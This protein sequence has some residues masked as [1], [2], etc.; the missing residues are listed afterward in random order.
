MG[1]RK[2]P[3]RRAG[4]CVAAALAVGVGGCAVPD[5][6]KAR[7]PLYGELR[8]GFC[9]DLPFEVLEER[10]G[11]R[12]GPFDA[13]TGPFGSVELIGLADTMVGHCEMHT[14]TA[15]RR[16][17]DG[18]VRLFVRTYSSAGDAA[19]YFGSLAQGASSSAGTVFGDLVK[20]VDGLRWRVDS[21]GSARWLSEF[22]VVMLDRNV[23]VSLDVRS[24]TEDSAQPGNPMV[25]AIGA[26]I[27]EM[28]GRFR[29]A[30]PRPT[31]QRA[32]ARPGP[33]HRWPSKGSCAD[34]PFDLFDRHL[35]AALPGYPGEQFDSAAPT[36][37]WC[38][39]RTSGRVDAGH[40]RRGAMVSVWIGP[41]ETAQEAVDFFDSRFAGS[42]LPTGHAGSS[43]DVDRLNWEYTEPGTG[44]DGLYAV[45]LVDGN[46]FVYLEV[47]SYS[48]NPVPVVDAGMAPTVGDFL[49]AALAHARSAPDTP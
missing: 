34:L 21:G 35:G 14:T 46:L 41:H 43:L 42:P 22:G 36:V 3:G 24:A 48:D 10:L 16:V 12:E 8:H 2:V 25:T 15:G 23:V 11:D 9:A 40:K 27:T 7:P 18:L 49:R 13:S 39:T 32:E 19:T 6:G 29:S 26:F 30:P 5:A 44:H 33:S 45:R 17:P 20:D 4:L 1:H 47:K 31:G 38:H 37:L 28:L